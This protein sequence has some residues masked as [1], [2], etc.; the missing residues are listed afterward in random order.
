[1]SADILRERLESG[2]K[3]LWTGGPVSGGDSKAR[4]PE[5]AVKSMYGAI[6]KALTLPVVLATA[7]AI[8]IFG[9]LALMAVPFWIVLGILLFLYL[10]PEN[11]IYGITDKCVFV[12]TQKSGI[13]S[14]SFGNISDIK[15]YIG[16]NGIN[17]YGKGKCLRFLRAERAAESLWDTDRRNAERLIS[18]V[19]NN[20]KNFK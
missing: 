17:F 10:R 20:G 19:I 13:A 4:P 7:A 5:P 11:W 14:Y 15:Q 16:K 8:P 1:M 9:K 2:E 3:L 12:G 6:L 18:G